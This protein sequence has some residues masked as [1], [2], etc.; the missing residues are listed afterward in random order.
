MSRPSDDVSTGS[1]DDDYEIIGVRQVARNTSIYRRHASITV[2]D[3]IN[4]SELE[5]AAGQIITLQHTLH[6]LATLTLTFIAKLRTTNAVATLSKTFSGILALLTFCD[7]SLDDLVSIEMDIRALRPEDHPPL[8][9]HPKK[10]RSI[11]SISPDFAYRVTRFTKEHLRTLFIHLR[12]PHTVILPRRRYRFTG[13]E[14]L[15]VC[16][17]RLAT[18]DPWIRL[19]PNYFGGGV[20]RWSPA[21]EWFINHIFVLFY[22]KISGNSL[23]MWSSSMVEFRRVM[24]RKFTS[25]PCDLETWANVG[26]IDEEVGLYLVDIPFE[27]FLYGMLVDDTNVNTT[28][29]GAGP[30]GDYVMAPR[31]VGAHYIQRAFYSGYFRGYGLKY[32]HILLPNGLFGSVWGTAT[33]YNDTGVA[34]MSGLEDY[35]FATL[36]PDSNGNLPCALAD[37]IFTESA[38]VMTTKVRVGAGQDEKRVYHRLTSIRQPIELQY[39]NFFNRFRLFKNEDAFCLFTNAELAYRTGI[40]G[41]F[42]LNCHTCLNG[43]V[44]NAFFR[45][46]APLITEYIPI[47][48]ELVE[49][50]RNV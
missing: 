17:A 32:Q 37:G 46:R 39:G 41:F 34:N 21:F 36:E 31:R 40:V 22:H 35:M 4:L 47:D 14:I 16:L 1:D 7:N 12:L 25:P 29:P 23:A 26:T 24:H 15:I 44:V 19:I 13:E 18:G 11:D 33:N 38:V 48:E 20:A 2:D 50:T 43:S 27:K 5:E 8:M 49:Y 28:R 30:D 42:L 6:L 9:I 3:A 10:N 45:S